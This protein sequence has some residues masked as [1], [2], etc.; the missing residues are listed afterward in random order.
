MQKRQQ[1]LLTYLQKFF[2]PLKNRKTFSKQ[3][4][5]LPKKVHIK[6]AHVALLCSVILLFASFSR[7]ISPQL[8][9]IVKAA[10]NLV[11]AT[12][13]DYEPPAAV[14]LIAPEDE[15]GL[16]TSSVT[17]QWYGTTDERGMSYYQLIIDNLNYFGDLPLTSYSTSEY[18]MTYDSGSNIYTLTPTDE[19]NDGTHYWYVRAYDITDLYTDSDIW[20][21]TIDTTAP[22]FVITDIGDEEVSISAADPGSVPSSP[23]ELDDNEPLFQGTGESGS[24]VQAT[25]TIP[26]DPTQNF[27]FSISGG[28]W[29]LQLGILPRDTT[30]EA[31]FVITDAVGNVSVLNDVPFRI[32]SA[33]STATP[34]PSPTA[35]PTPTP[36]PSPSPS[37]NPSPSPSASPGVSPTPTAEPTATPTPSPTPVVVATS[38]T[39]SPSPTP[40]PIIQLPPDLPVTPIRPREAAYE[41]IQETIERIPVSVRVAFE[42]IPDGVKQTVSQAAPYSVAV[43]TAAVPAWTLLQLLQYWS[44]F[45]FGFLIRI[46]QALGLLP[47]GKSRGLV[48]NSKTY[49]PVPFALLTFIQINPQNPEEVD[50]MLIRETVVTDTDGIYKGITLPEGTYRIAVSHQDFSFPSQRPR[51]VQFSMHDFYLGEPFDITSERDEVSFLI[52]VDPLSDEA[53]AK[54]RSAKRS[55]QFAPI[56]RAL[57][58]L[59]WPLF[60]LSIILAVYRPTYWNIGV[61][62]LYLL[63]ISKRAVGLARRPRILGYVKDVAGAPIPYTVIRISDSDK[64]EL[65]GITTTDQ[66]GRYQYFGKPKRYQV[67]IIKPGYVWQ[68]QENALSYTEIDTRQKRQRFDATLISVGEIYDELFEG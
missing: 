34:T 50:E 28:V 3:L 36:S 14:A 65:I 8:L 24:S 40:R 51:P 4:H 33:P 30:I 60:I 25:F 16:T 29:N 44:Q 66:K 21:F 22:A 39:P 17:F 27:T 61:F 37:T 52:P 20:E 56:K 31:D 6:K 41:V 64:N 62:W 7:T 48:Y 26:G 10:T 13:P 46:L 12:V 43:A 59:T 67:N 1:N 35:T 55:I 58:S 53:D 54:A 18:T 49:E 9:K 68:S 63:I 45:S 2:S 38:P 11:T 32:R 47:V 5:F 42:N 19:F 57:G 23:V 15:A